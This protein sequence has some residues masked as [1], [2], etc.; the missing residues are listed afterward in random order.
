[1]ESVVRSLY[2]IHTRRVR[3]N[4]FDIPAVGGN[5]SVCDCRLTVH[6]SDDQ[7]VAGANEIRLIYGHEIYSYYQMLNLITIIIKH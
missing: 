3:E 5:Q 4:N 1:M 7:V 6:P 2:I